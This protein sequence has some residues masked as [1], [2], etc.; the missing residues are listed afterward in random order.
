MKIIFMGNGKIGYRVLK[1]LL[2]KKDNVV[3]AVIHPPERA[4]YYDEITG[5]LKKNRI[6]F[7]HG[8]K[9]RTRTVISR[10][11][12]CNADIILSMNF[13]YILRPE[14]FTRAERGTIN[15]HTSY[16]PYNKG[17]NPNVW[18]LVDGTPAGVSLHY[19][20]EGV[21]EGDVIFQKEVPVSP[22]DTGRSLYNKLESAAVSLFKQ[23]WGKI[24]EGKVQKIRIQGKGTFHYVKDM[25]KL[26]EIDLDKKY[27]ARELID[28]LRARTFPPH[29]GSYFIVDGKKYYME[30]KIKPEQEEQ[31]QK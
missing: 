31:G 16:L 18:S 6:E 8:D 4:R 28:I 3:Y 27:T 24:K 25:E 9:L 5:L 22:A 7:T 21:D 26:D 1:Y 13:G 20:N 11:K 30:L 14:V 12:K 19:I 29:K 23:S 2:E 17:A 15:L 10:I